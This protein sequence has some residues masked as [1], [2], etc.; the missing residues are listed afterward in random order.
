MEKQRISKVLIRS[1][2][3]EMQRHCDE[4]LSVDQKRKGNALHCINHTGGKTR[5]GRFT[6]EEIK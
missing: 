4:E 2:C 5:K 3:R 1:E 6:W